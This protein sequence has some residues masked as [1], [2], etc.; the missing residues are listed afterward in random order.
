MAPPVV[1]L[2]TDFGLRDPYVAAMKGV[3]RAGCPGLTVDDLSH[4]I[5]PQDLR[6][7][8][9]FLEA[10]IPCY[11]PGTIHLVVVD[12]GVGGSRRP[13]A[14]RLPDGSLLVGPDNGVLSLAWGRAP[15]C[16]EITHPDLPR[17]PCSNT[18]HGR[19]LFAP[20]AARLAGGF[21]FSALGPPIGDPCRIVLPQPRGGPGE[22]TGEIIHL[23]HFG[24]AVSNLPAAWAGP[25]A[26]VR[27]RGLDLPIHATYSA[28][29]V[30][31]PLA[32]AGSTARIEVAV[33]EGD[34]GRVL[35]LRVG[36]EIAIITN[37]GI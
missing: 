24:N 32:L 13:M 9:L 6:A 18:F 35:G 37:N 27:V 8:A 19:D 17:R 28:V 22:A 15:E 1:T 29:P 30:G 5:P 4:A 26:Q 20:A 33:R 31:A 11:P 2:T 12:P 36:E 21:D 7:A 23:D 25:A 14:V 10:A 34:A 16:R 3:L